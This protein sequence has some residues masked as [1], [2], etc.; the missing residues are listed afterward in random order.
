MSSSFDPIHLHLVLNR[1][2]MVGWEW[3]DEVKGTT[4]EGDEDGL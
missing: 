4:G 3:D 2:D 1:P